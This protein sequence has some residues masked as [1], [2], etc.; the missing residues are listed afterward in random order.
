MKGGERKMSIDDWIKMGKD[1]GFPILIVMYFMIRLNKS[2]C[3]LEQTVRSLVQEI[4]E[5][6]GEG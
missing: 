1:V 6:K 2:F 4:H 3:R 5:K